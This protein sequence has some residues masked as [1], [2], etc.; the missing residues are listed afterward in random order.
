LLRNGT[1]QDITPPANVS[2]AQYVPETHH[3]IPDVFRTFLNQT[4]IIYSG[5]RYSNGQLFDWV[6]AFGYPIGDAYWMRTN[7][8]GVAQ[9]SLVQPF[10][11][12]ILTYTPSNTAGYQVEM[13]NVGQ[14]YYRWRY[15]N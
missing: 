14:H 15:G 4:G 1:F 13:G 12:R 10:E 7:I 11:R 2:Y 8:A 9:W 6:G 3:N 5:G